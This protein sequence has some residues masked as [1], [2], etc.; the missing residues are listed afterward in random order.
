MKRLL[1]G[2][3]ALCYIVGGVYAQKNY[4][5]AIGL[6][7]SGE[8][9]SLSYRSISLI[10]Q[11]KGSL[12]FEFNFGGF[13]K[14]NRLGFESEIYNQL[15]VNGYLEND[16][17]KNQENRFF[18]YA[19]VQYEY[20]LLQGLG[21]YGGIGFGIDYLEWCQ[22]D[23]YR[24]NDY[25]YTDAAFLMSRLIFNV[26]IDYK[27]PILPINVSLDWMP[28]SNKLYRYDEFNDEI[29]TDGKAYLGSFSVAARFTWGNKKSTKVKN[30]NKLSEDDLN[31]W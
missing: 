1:I 17:A 12:G 4:K 28:R 9:L 10:G 21:A 22:G 2:L 11:E 27:I 20:S 16:V 5:N 3:I 18:G 26:G 19:T 8:E 6:R 30:N 13:L 14:S 29:Y 23:C 24:V 7:Y 25:N 15:E 31:T